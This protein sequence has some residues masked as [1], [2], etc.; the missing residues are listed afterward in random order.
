VLWVRE[1]ELEDRGLA[2][3]PVTTTSA[4]KAT[5]R[6]VLGV[7]ATSLGQVVV[8]VT[9]GVQA[10]LV[11][12]K[13]GVTAATD[14]FFAAYSVYTLV[15]LVAMSW[16]TT[17]VARMVEADSPHGSFNR[18]CGAAGL[19]FAVCGILFV[20]LGGPLA[21]F[22]TGDLPPVATATARDS[23]VIL[24][25]AAGGQLVAALAAAALGI[26]GD[27]V[28][29]A[30]ALSAGSLVSIAGFLALEPFWG[31]TA[32]PSAIL[33]GSVVT[34]T[35]LLHAMWR[36]GWRP[37][38]TIIVDVVP[39]ARA[40][41]LALVSSLTN[42]F[43]YLVFVVSIAMAARLGEGTTTLYTYAY[44]ALG[45]VTTLV[46]SSVAIVLAAPLAAVWDRR[47]SSLRPY[48]DDVFRIGLMIVIPI[49]A[50]AV[51]LADDVVRAVF[52]EFT[53][54]E[55]DTLVLT[56]LILSPS[57]ASTV[58]ATIPSLALITL[59]RYP[60]TAVIALAALGMQ[61]G[62]SFIALA[63][64]SVAVLAAASAA[65]SIARLLGSMVVLYRPGFAEAC[66]RLGRQLLQLLLPAVACFAAPA[67]LLYVESNALA[68]VGTYVIGLILYG[69]W[70]AA[71]M[72]AH[73]LLAMRLLH[74]LRPAHAARQA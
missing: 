28:R 8:G 37:S 32:L 59:G 39:N 63:L 20:A 51:L 31:I 71:F 16:R 12:A 23:L 7:G 19:V 41:G 50:A 6:A 55:I 60:T 26:R 54:H 38:R 11:A 58:A 56:F 33:I 70:I 49:A 43:V 42:V 25:L 1:N 44:F 35:P 74:S 65:A 14:G 10:A 9:S 13:F 52:P 40:A 62:F 36:A 15:V 48:A 27:Y 64:H 22:L 61:V 67:L 18:F 47:P 5:R 69:A 66:L 21:S 72:P 3:V 30:V 53:E 73:R 45:L 24:W 46:G 4:P 17:L 34:V 2:D 68:A 29:P 57:M